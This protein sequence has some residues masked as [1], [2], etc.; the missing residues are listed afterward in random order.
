MRGT[1]TFVCVIVIAWCLVV[2]PVLVLGDQPTCAPG[3]PFD[4]SSISSIGDPLSQLFGFFVGE[5]DPPWL[6]VPSLDADCSLYIF[7]TSNAAKC[8]IGTHL[9]QSNNPVPDNDYGKCQ[10]SSQN[11]CPGAATASCNTGTNCD[12]GNGGGSCPAFVNVAN[13]SP[14]Y[15]KCAFASTTCQASTNQCWGVI[16]C[17]SGPVATTNPNNQVPCPS[18]GFTD[19]NSQG[20]PAVYFEGDFCVED[21]GSGNTKWCG[22]CPPGTVLSNNKKSCQCL[23]DKNGNCCPNNQLPDVTGTC[24]PTTLLLNGAGSIC[25][26]FPPSDGRCGGAPTHGD[27]QIGG[28][29]GQ[30]FQFHG[31]A[32]EV[33]N[34]I[35][36]PSLQVNG[37]FVY[38][39]SGKCDY[40][41]T[42][43]WSHPGTYIDQLGFSFSS[44]RV[45]VI[46]GPHRVGMHIDMDGEKL[47]K[48]NYQFNT[49]GS[50]VTI[51]FK[52]RGTVQINTQQFVFNIFNSDTF[53]NMEASMLDEVLLRIGSPKHTITD[54]SLCRKEEALDESKLQ[55]SQIKQVHNH[56]AVEAAID[57]KYGG[58]QVPLHGLIGQTWRNVLVCGKHWVGS[59][60]DYLASD[61]FAQDYVFNFFHRD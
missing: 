47:A 1:G 29:Q 31:L 30:S 35:S 13:G 36:T 40:N 3:S 43:C 5:V 24:C 37:R 33:F 25:C 38:L 10:S 56:G 39:S 28:F 15:P 41:D 34:L 48:G 16:E 59:V 12:N 58:T 23:V 51:H 18:A 22:N 57:K 9:D 44:H 55:R 61:L 27:P 14:V 49:N 8:C 11:D 42:Q 50:D 46:A 32:D 6:T 2:A 53:F 60:T 21:G 17:Y 7:D 52:N 26:Q 45:K 20:V 4:F 54:S 19:S